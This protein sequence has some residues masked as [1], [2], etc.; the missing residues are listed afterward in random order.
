[1][2]KYLLSILILFSTNIAASAF[3]LSENML[4]KSFDR[5][6]DLLQLS[7]EELLEVEVVVASKTE[8]TIFDAPSTVTVFTRQQLRRMGVNSVE[9]LLNFVPGFIATRE[10][11][12]G[13]GY[14][15][16]ARGST[17]P[18]SSYNV[19]FM[20][21]GQRLNNDL[22]GGALDAYGHFISLANV[23][24]IEIIRGPGSASYGT[25]AM[26]GVVNIV[27]ATD[28]NDAFVSVGNLDSREAYVNT[29]RKGKNWSLSLS[30]RHFEDQGQTYTKLLIPYQKLSTQ[31]PNNGQD[32]QLRLSYDKFRLNLRHSKRHSDDF[33]LANYIGNG[34][35][36]TVGEQNFITFD[37]KLLDNARWDIS[38]EG[39][40]SKIDTDSIAE[41][42]SQQTILALPP[43]VI[44]TGRVA[45][46]E[47]TYS[48]ESAWN[49]GINGRYRFNENHTFFAGLSGYQ[50]NIDKFRR[51][52][53]YNSSQLTG[54]LSQKNPAG[55]LT[56]YENPR[57]LQ[58]SPETH[59][60]LIGLYLQHKYQASQQV[61]LTWGARY[62]HYPDVG[63]TINP[64]AALVY[65]P[66]DKTK[67]KW[68]YGEAFRAPAIF[69]TSGVDTGN[70]QLKPEKIK[71]MELAW[72]QQ[73][74]N[75]QTALTYFYSR[76]SNKIDTVLIPGTNNRRF[77]NLAG[78]LD[79][80][81]W[82][83]E[84]STEIGKGLSLRAAYTLMQKTEENPRRF[85]KQTFSLIAN[86]HYNDWDFNLNTFFHDSIQQQIAKGGLVDLSSYWVVNGTIRYALFNKVALIGKVN[87]LFDE[88]Y[89]SSSKSAAFVEGV[90]NRGRT[91]AL[92]VEVRF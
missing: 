78:D 4:A 21:D 38:I 25:G 74:Q 5:T 57:E 58:V 15:V 90:P 72:L 75:F 8:E 87:N 32:V 46:T 76:A 47:R 61:A 6:E 3:S 77:E 24:Q 70:P 39:G 55:Q 43:S 52:S 16:S 9:E 44:T 88:D 62:D 14:M 67:F 13:Q 35:N 92:G 69:Q 64:R 80:A 40:Y 11:V 48:K 68:L 2:K 60:N 91:Y 17:T 65:S 31:D 1:M 85:P 79:T 86:Y 53:N 18:Q 7:L 33:Y 42:V 63:S 23:K 30:A 10:I 56:Y 27:T 50:P 71:T 29:S 54:I 28:I 84:A 59:R 45:A 19:L 26:T 37:Y 89:Y 36:M 73:H 83:M 49:L 22:R 81:G 34:N 20:L 51:V 12:F 66:T 41:T 82:E